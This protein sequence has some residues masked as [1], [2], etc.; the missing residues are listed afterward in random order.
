M[1]LTFPFEMSVF[2]NASG[3]STL[4]QKRCPQL[5]DA[6]RQMAASKRADFHLTSYHQRVSVPRSDLTRDEERAIQRNMLSGFLLRFKVVCCLTC[7]SRF[8]HVHPLLM[9]LYHPLHHPRPT[10]VHASPISID[11]TPPHTLSWLCLE[12]VSALVPQRY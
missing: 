2:I 11:V 12:L 7:P 4:P 3:S 5:A 9:C 10:L 1:Y 8:L 6:K